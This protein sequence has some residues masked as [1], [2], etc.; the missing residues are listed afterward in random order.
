MSLSIKCLPFLKDDLDVNIE[1]KKQ[2]VP[3][4]VSQN[5]DYPSFS[6]AVTVV[7]TADKGK[8]D[9]NIRPV[10]PSPQAGT[11]WPAVTS[12]WGRCCVWRSRFPAYWHRRNLVSSGGK[13]RRSSEE[14]EE[15]EEHK[16]Q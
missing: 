4:I 1:A 6:D 13:E 14:R 5:L 9:A 11:W 7:R 2:E 8:F 15:G 3:R 16:E 12:R 10:S